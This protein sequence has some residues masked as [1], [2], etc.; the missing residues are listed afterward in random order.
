MFNDGKLSIYKKVPKQSYGGQPITILEFYKRSFYGELSFG[1][2]EYYNAKR[3]QVQIKKRVRI[4]QDKTLSNKHV[5][6]IDNEQYEVG[7][8]YSTKAKG[9]DITDITLEGVEANYDIA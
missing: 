7:R 3:E 8:T 1:V 2:E 9:I 5:V 4:H 6:L